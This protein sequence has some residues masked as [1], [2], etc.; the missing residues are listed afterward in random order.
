MQDVTAE[1]IR[2]KTGTL[3]SVSSLAG[4]MKNAECESLI[5]SILLNQ[6]LDSKQAKEIED[7]IVQA[8]YDT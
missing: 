8:L 2:A 4:Y 3:T 7:R 1:N 6:V 5:F